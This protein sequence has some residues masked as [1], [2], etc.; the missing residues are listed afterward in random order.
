M[1]TKDIKTPLTAAQINEFSD[2]D[3]KDLLDSTA[4]IVAARLKLDLKTSA[5]QTRFR[6]LGSI[7]TTSGMVVNTK[8]WSKGVNTSSQRSVTHVFGATRERSEAPSE[9]VILEWQRYTGESLWQYRM[10]NPINPSLCLCIK[11]LT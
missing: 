11:H 5:G 6:S 10:I 1:A 8:I 7:L 3:N 9:E 2:L 4:S